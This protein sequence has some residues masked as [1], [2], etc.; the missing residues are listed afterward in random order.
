[1]TRSRKTG[2]RRCRAIAAVLVVAPSA[3]SLA[4]AAAPSKPD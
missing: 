3:D 4:M 1:M 2:E